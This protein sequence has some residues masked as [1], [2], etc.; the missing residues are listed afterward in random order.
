MMPN[1]LP[2][3]ILAVLAIMAGIW[4]LIDRPPSQ[5]GESAGQRLLPGLEEKLNNV[6]R[7]RIEQAGDT[8]DVVKTGGQWQLPDRGGYPVMF[9]RVKPL[10]L[11]IALLEKIEPKTDKPDNY[12]RLG[13]QAP[14]AGSDNMRIS[15][16]TNGDHPVASLIVGNIRHGMLAGGH[17]GIYVRVP[18]QARAWLTAGNLELPRA[19]VDWV[20]RQIVHIKPKTVKRVTIT[21]PDGSQLTIERARRGAPDFSIP[22]MPDGAT[23]KDSMALNPL[24]RSLA[25]LKMEDVLV[26]SEAGL[27]EAEAV[28]AV[29]ETWDGLQLTAHTVEQD[30]RIFA[31]FDVGA[32]ALDMTDL[33][34]VRTTQSDSTA[35]RARLAGWVFQIPR[36]RG[37]KL[38]RRLEDL[39]SVPE[40]S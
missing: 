29:F 38:R 34:A 5:P 11:G 28:S 39:V 22:D 16:Y 1:K 8:Y 40:N 13:V 4:L 14:A 31:W 20:D 23:V 21:H 30:N 24:A 26:R 36:A 25:G 12:V 18:D 35:L 10:L 2:V 15:L 37:E 27:P 3:I 6:V 33:S 32:A 19:R 7:I 17:D 9:E